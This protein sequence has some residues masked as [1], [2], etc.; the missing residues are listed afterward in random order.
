MS[1]DKFTSNVLSP[2]TDCRPVTKSDSTNLP[3]GYT[4]A[5]WVGGAGDVAVRMASGQNATFVGVPAGTR[6][7]IVVDRVLD[8][9]TTAT[10]L[11]AMH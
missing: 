2:S 7:D 9:G 11:V 3:G 4:R 1:L 8:T 5:L 6:L 10:S